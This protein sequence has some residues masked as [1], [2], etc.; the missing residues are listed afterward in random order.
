[1]TCPFAS[2]VKATA[3][4]VAVHTEDIVHDFY[5][6]LFKNDAEIT[7]YFNPANQFADPPLQRMALANAVVAYGSN[8]DDLTPLAG[9]VQVIATKH[10]ALQVKPEHYPKVD[11]NLAAAILAVIGEDIV[12]PEVSGAWREAVQSLAKILIAAEEEIVQEAAKRSGGWL[13]LKDF[14]IT[15]IRDVTEACREFTFESADGDTTPIDFTAGQFLTVHLQGEGLTPRHYSVTNAPG[16]NFLQCCVKKVAKGAVSN[17]LHAMKEGDVVP[18]APPMGLF[19]MN[20]RPAVLISAGIGATPMKSFLDSSASNVKL[21]VHVDRNETT[22]PFKTEMEASGVETKFIYT[23]KSGRPVPGELVAELQPYIADH[24]FYLC[25]S[26]DFSGE[27]HA[28]L[29]VAGVSNIFADV[30]GPT[31]AGAHLPK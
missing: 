19:K 28:A 5:P 30:F 9:A 7:G 22:H 27:I 26:A 23:Q 8:I 3:P 2:I 21:V 13:G 11:E 24:D 31:L 4:L 10:A 16:R 18:L 29:K 17:A 1:M 15:S 6:R 14:K 12:T 20:D 25:A